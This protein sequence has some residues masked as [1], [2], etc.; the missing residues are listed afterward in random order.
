MKLHSFN[1]TVSCTSY[2]KPCIPSTRC[3]VP[4]GG[5]QQKLGER[6][7]S[8][9]SSGLQK[10]VLLKTMGKAEGVKG[11]E[12]NPNCKTCAI[13]RALGLPVDASANILATC[14]CIIIT[15]LLVSVAKIAT[16]AATLRQHIQFH[17]NFSWILMKLK[18]TMERSDVR[19]QRL[20]STN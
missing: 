19:C 8:S 12:Y 17:G 15:S 6:E 4:C 5:L 20:Y 2:L 1:S 3:R 14:V 13:M 7:S 11:L 16:W 9:C 18:M 10:F